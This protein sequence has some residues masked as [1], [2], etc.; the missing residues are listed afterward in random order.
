[1]E[2]NG[3]PETAPEQAV[4]INLATT[5]PVERNR[6]TAAIR[7]IM[8]IPQFFVLFFVGIAA[9]VVL[10]IGWFGALFTGR[11]PDFAEEFLS[12]VLRWE[13]RVYAYLYFLTDDYPPFSLQH[14]EQYPIVVDVP[15]PARLSLLAVLFRIILV[16]PAWIVVSV[17][18]YGLGVVAF[19]SW[20]M[21]LF[22]GKLPEPLYEATRAVVR[23]GARVGGYFAMLTP[24]YPWGILGD[25]PPDG[26]SSTELNPGVRGSWTLRLSP[27]GRT[28]MIVLLVIGVILFV[29]NLRRY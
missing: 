1:M 4:P 9:A 13:T 16:I 6:L 14:E 3:Y 19:A 26:E 5:P 15:P 7:I 18:G 11:L 20:F 29:V 28:A 8:V 17:A 12:G 23:F 22:T 27:S 24:E 25:G 2:A 21:I 10:I